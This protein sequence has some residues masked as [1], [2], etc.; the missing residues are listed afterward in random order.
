MNIAAK[1]IPSG[2]FGLRVYNSSLGRSFNR[3][4]Q[5]HIGVS[6]RFGFT[7]VMRGTLKPICVCGIA[8]VLLN[9]VYSSARRVEILKVL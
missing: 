5:H 9:R 8:A 2:I 6:E 1:I 4:S 3:F 7:S